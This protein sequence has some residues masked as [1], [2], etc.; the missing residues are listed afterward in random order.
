MLFRSIEMDVAEQLE[1]IRIFFADDGFVPVL[2]KM[3]GSLVAKIED[4][5]VAGQQAAHKAGEFETFATQQEVEMI[6]E[7]GPGK[8]LGLGL[9]E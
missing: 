3:A 4:Y 6:V 1:E 7:H 9:D 5:G 2:K 8:A